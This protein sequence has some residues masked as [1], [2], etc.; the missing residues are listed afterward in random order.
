[1]YPDHFQIWSDFGH[2]LFIFSILTQFWLGETGKIRG[3]R[4]FSWE[5]MEEWHGIM[6]TLSWPP[7][8]IIKFWS[9]SVDF[10]HFSD[11]LTYWNRSNLEFPG[12]L[13]VT[14]GRNG[15]KYPAHLPSELMRFW[16]NFVLMKLKK[17]YVYYYHLG[18]D[19]NDY[20]QFWNDVVDRFINLM[21]YPT[22]VVL[23][24]SRSNI[25]LSCLNF[26]RHY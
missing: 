20:P 3:F 18:N 10:P 13:G 26:Q 7:S 19:W 25:Q 14:H 4:T 8:E 6:H 22:D 24:L 1:M 5:R 17:C 9:R 12:I 11:T 15:Q 16:L 2:G 21:A 23:I